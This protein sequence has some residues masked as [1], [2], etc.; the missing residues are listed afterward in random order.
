M[1]DAKSRYSETFREAEDVSPEQ[2]REVEAPL[3]PAAPQ[4]GEQKSCVDCGADTPYLRCSACLLLRVH[5]KSWKPGA[6]EK[7]KGAPLGAP[8]QPFVP[9]DPREAFDHFWT[10]K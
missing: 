10:F 5:K 7:K 8:V 1:K 9:K 4:E 6:P 2:A 3:E